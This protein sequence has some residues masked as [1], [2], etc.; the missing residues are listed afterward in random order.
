MAGATDRLIFSNDWPNIKRVIQ[1][2][3]GDTHGV[4]IFCHTLRPNREG[5]F[6]RH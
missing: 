1:E 4:Y 3:E 6:T 2:E 5:A